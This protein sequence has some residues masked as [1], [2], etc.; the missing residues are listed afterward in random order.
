MIS[1]Q[2]F[3]FLDRETNVAI[4]AFKSTAGSDIVNSAENATK[5]SSANLQSLF[6]GAKQSFTNTFGEVEI[7]DSLKDITRSSKGFS[8]KITDLTKLPDT[9]LGEYFGGLTGGDPGMT[10]A[11]KNIMSQCSSRGMGSGFPG[12]PFDMS[13]NCGQGNVKIANSP[14]GSSCN[15]GSFGNLLNKLSG[16]GYNSVFRDFNAALRALMALAGYGYKLGMCGVF[17]A[18]SN[19]LP[20]DV[21]SKGSGGLMAIVGQA[22][23]TNAMLDLAKSSTGLL[24][25]VHNPSA[26][27]TFLGNYTKPKSTKEKDL[28]GLADRTFGGLDLLNEDWGM[29]LADNSPSISEAPGYQK[30]LGVTMKAKLVDRS[31]GVTDLDVAPSNDMDFMLAAYEMRA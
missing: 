8:G 29:S 23:N 30:D 21:L 4:D 25:L 26:I 20:N 3:K 13:I 6:D 11:M 22:G 27:S 28:P 10:K 16:G 1:G 14:G 15:A 17:G 18:V 9:K 31:F 5:E 19:G 2:R 12:K 24:P 7:P